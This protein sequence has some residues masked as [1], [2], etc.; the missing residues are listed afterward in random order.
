MRCST[1]W[2]STT[3]S[4][5]ANVHRGVYTIAEE[6]TAAFEAARAKVARFLGAAQPRTRSSSPRNATEAINLVAYSWGARQPRAR[7]TPSCSPR[8][9]TTPTSCR[10]TSSPPSAASS[11]AGSR[12]PPTTASTSADLDRAAR[13]RQAAS[14]SPR[15]RTCSAPSTTS[16]PS[17][18]PPTPPARTCSSTPRQAVPHLA[19]DVQ[20]WDADFVGFTG[21]QDARPD[22]ASAALWARPR[23]ARGDAAVPRRRRDDPRRPQRR[24]HDQRGAVEVRGGHAADRRGRRLRRRGRLPRGARHGRDPRARASRSPATRSTRC[25]DRFGD[26]LTIYGPLDTA[27][28]GGVD[29]VP[30]RRHPRPRHLAGRSTKRPSACGPATTAPSRSCACSASPPP[31]ARRSTFTTTKPTPTPSSTR[32]AR[33]EKFFAI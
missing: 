25:S 12:S 4:Y 5:Y 15:C 32:S 3:A 7:A 19:V 23:A 2:T 31:P 21:P 20:A 1:R 11:C 18:T 6:A 22:A 13:R 17:P 26:R 30:L 28:R 27:V 16:G 33:A 10:G 29:L 24:L 9:S 14:R 8:W